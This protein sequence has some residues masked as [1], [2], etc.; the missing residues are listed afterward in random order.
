MASHR[1]QQ[2]PQDWPRSIC[3]FCGA[4]QGVPA[5]HVTL[6]QE[7][8]RQLAAAGITV[9]YGGA[10]RGLMG[11]L[12]DATLQAGGRMVGI[13]PEYL[14]DLEV[15]HRDLHELL[16]VDSMH[17]RK[18]LMTERSD[19]FCVLPGGIGTLEEAFEALTWAQLGLHAKPLVFLDPD[20]FWDR[21]EQLLQS[22][23]HQGYLRVPTNRVLHRV[24]TPQALLE[25]LRSF[26]PA[27]TPGLLQQQRG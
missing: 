25:A 5:A 19:A 6:A 11:A 12:A 14:V 16:V 23:E 9:V 17:E 20:G 4:S 3:V 7:L 22:M 1:T 18:R 15:A 26:E 2:A 21:L 27:V 24:A 10:R 8:G 13:I